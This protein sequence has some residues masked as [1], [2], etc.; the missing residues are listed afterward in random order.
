MVDLCV[1][2][3]L[4]ATQRL[5]P[6]LEV[7]CITDLFLNPGELEG[8]FLCLDIPNFVGCPVCSSRVRWVINDRV[9]N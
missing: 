9:N 5:W 3:F 2:S 6:Q 4:D 1:V 7:Y 8:S